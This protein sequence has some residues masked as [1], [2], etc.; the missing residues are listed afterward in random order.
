MR[1]T[2]CA[3]AS[4]VS[5][6]L[7]GPRLSIPGA[8][9]NMNPQSLDEPREDQDGV[10]RNGGEGLHAFDVQV[11]MSPGSINPRDDGT[12]VASH[13]HGQ[14]RGSSSQGD[15]RGAEGSGVPS[16]EVNRK[17]DLVCEAIA[18][19]RFVIALTQGISRLGDVS[20]EENIISRAALE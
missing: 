9:G 15:D 19:Q 18:T 8:P 10:Q 5:P 17:E 1:K 20:D 13:V 14:V 12:N 2:I 6:C 4:M 7:S 3:V 11:P 16:G